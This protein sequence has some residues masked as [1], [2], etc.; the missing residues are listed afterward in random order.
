[1]KLVL[2]ILIACACC[3][4]VRADQF[5]F[6]S[7]VGVVDADGEGRLCL[8]I[9]NPR[10]ADGA[11]VSL[12]LPERPQRVVKA[13]VEGKA[14]SDCTRNSTGGTE[15][16]FY[17]LK[18]SGGVRSLGEGPQPPAIAVVGPAGRVAVRRGTVSGDLDGDGRAEFFR[19][20]TS[21]E[22]NHLTIWTGKPL[23]GKRRWNA[24]YYLGYDVVPT[25]KKKDYQ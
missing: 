6:D 12:I 14:P 23:L 18:L 2:A 21:T 13:A 24:Y 16:S 11:E 3:A 10:L 22:G 4:A 9:S 20:C 1:M 17:W 7:G 15:T 19:I 5:S 25:C 8:N